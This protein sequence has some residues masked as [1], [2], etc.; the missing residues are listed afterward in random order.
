MKRWTGGLLA[1][2][3]AVVVAACGGSDGETASPE[4]LC[5]S[6]GTQ[7]KILNGTSCGQ[8]EQSSVILLEIVTG[9]GAARC[10]GTLLTPTK[11]LTAAHCLPADARQVLASAWS[12]DGNRVRVQAGGW[13]VHPQFQRSTSLLVNDVA[14]VFL[15]SALPNSTMGV[16]VSEPSAAGQSVFIAGWGEPGFGL[17]VGEAI[18]GLVNEVSVGFTYTG[19]LANTC[20][21]DSGGPAFRSVGGRYGVVGITSTGT[22]VRC[23]NG[24]RS[25]F[26]NVQGGAVINFIRSQA[27]DAAYL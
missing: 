5:N 17:A 18:L 27:P 10:S 23:G 15:S 21:G 7:P 9:S 20:K 13:A 12:S 25:L 19:D 16:L 2:M 3:A 6:I 24:D 14:V 26:T 11:V 4:A 1:C 8:P 22:V